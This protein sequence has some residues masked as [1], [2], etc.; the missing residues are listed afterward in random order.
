M[1]GPG[2]QDNPRLVVV[3]ARPQEAGGRAEVVLEMRQ[4]PGGGYVLPVFSSVAL[5]I[6]RLGRFQPWVCLP[7]ASVLPADPSVQVVIDPSID[8][9]A[10]RWQQ[11]ALEELARA[12]GREDEEQSR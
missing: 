2:S 8:E 10:P 6:E 7:L 11:P 1:T 4:Q 12:A 9:A 5:L 3:P